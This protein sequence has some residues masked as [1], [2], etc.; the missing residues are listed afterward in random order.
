MH[1]HIGPAFAD[2]HDQAGVGHDQ[3]IRLHVDHRRHVVEVGLDLGVVREDVADHEELVP[4]GMRFLDGAGEGL[5]VAELVVTRAQ[6][7]ARLA[8]IDGI[9]AK[10]EGGTHH[11]Q[12]TG[13]GKKLRGFHGVETVQSGEFDHYTAQAPCIPRHPRHALRY[14]LRATPGERPLLR[15]C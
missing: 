5:H 15:S 14:A 11:R 12:R 3:R 10:S 9:G 13:R 8:G 4:A 1:R 2:H 7:V 6:A